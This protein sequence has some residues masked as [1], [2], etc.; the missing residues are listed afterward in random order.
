M[1]REFPDT[2]GMEARMVF[3][4]AATSAPHR[5]G[6]HGVF[7][8]RIDEIADACWMHAETV[9]D[10][11]AELQQ[12]RLMA[13]ADDWV[14][15]ANTLPDEEE[16][17]ELTTQR[18]NKIVRDLEDLLNNHQHPLTRAIHRNRNYLVQQHVKLQV[19]PR[20]RRA[21]R[22]P[23]PVDP[24]AMP[25]GLTGMQ[26][27]QVTDVASSL[28]KIAAEYPETSKPVT[29]RGVANVLAAQSW[30]PDAPQ[31]AQESIYYWCDGEGRN[32]A[33]YRSDWAQVFLNHLK[34]VAPRP[35]PVGP[36]VV[37]QGT[38]R[39]SNPSPFAATG[40]DGTV[41]SPAFLTPGRTKP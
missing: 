20:S 27:Q 7:A 39:T 2:V 37:R 6:G 29:Y 38:G 30:R 34:H 19:T 4:W 3:Q 40:T 8:A 10:A 21:R 9:E 17:R 32:N 16:W 36:T 35:T 14:S 24:E 41:V 23:E 1:W 18:C 13:W 5:N 26:Q 28:R 12:A 31:L 11:L 33:P 15:L 22:A 25:D